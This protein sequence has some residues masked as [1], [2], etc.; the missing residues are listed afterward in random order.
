VLLLERDDGHEEKRK[1]RAG[2][3]TNDA[4]IMTLGTDT[5]GR[6]NDFELVIETK[7]E[8]Y[9]EKHD[10]SGSSVRSFRGLRSVAPTVETESNRALGFPMFFILLC[11]DPMIL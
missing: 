11:S 10:R 6:I 2:G 8:G 4:H 9:E 7:K 3:S 1:P 5:G